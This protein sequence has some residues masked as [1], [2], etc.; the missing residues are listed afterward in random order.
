M[1]IAT[2]PVLDHNISLD[3]FGGFRMADLTL[4]QLKTVIS[5]SCRKAQFFYSVFLARL[6]RAWAEINFFFGTCC[7]IVLYLVILAHAL[8]AFVYGSMLEAV[9][10]LR[11]GRS[12]ER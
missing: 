12:S 6:A 8:I 10:W 4:T 3:R 9:A 2:G 7:A 5:G 11:R 1:L